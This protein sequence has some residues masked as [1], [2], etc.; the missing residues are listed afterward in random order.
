M[1]VQT[2]LAA[3]GKQSSIASCFNGVQAEFMKT[4]VQN[5]IDLRNFVDA[6]SAAKGL[7]HFQV[8]APAAADDDVVHAALAGTAAVTFPG[9][10]VSPDVPRNLSLVMGSGYDGG[11]VTVTGTDVFNNVLTESFVGASGVTRT[12]SKIFKTVTGIVKAA[13]G[14]NAATVKV[15]TG[16]KLGV[17]AALSAAVGILLVDGVAEAAT[18][19]ATN[20]SF[21]PG[22]HLADGA[23]VFDFLSTASALAL[24][25]PNTIGVTL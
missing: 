7:R 21:L 14:V 6:L 20:G 1:A 17:T 10:I 9:P 18:I 13:V 24:S 22:T 4:L 15:G 8:S 16:D 2:P 23:R 25:T 3:P 12:G 11:T 19:D 5:L